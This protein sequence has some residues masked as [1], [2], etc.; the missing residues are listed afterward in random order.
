LNSNDA[1]L[2]QT[3]RHYLLGELTPEDSS[4]VEERLLIDDDF[5]HELLAG[6]DDLIDDYLSSELSAEGKRLF[7]N[8]FMTTPERREKLRFARGLKKYV[9][10]VG[11]VAAQTAV[12]GVTSAA[13]SKAAKPP[14]DK[15]GWSWFLPRQNPALSYSLAAASFL[16]V[17]VGAV[18]II[19][20]VALKP[21]TE[22]RVL[23]VELASGLT[24]SDEQIKTFSV[25]N[26]DTVELDLRIDQSDDYQLYRGVLQTIDGAE[27][28]RDDVPRTNS[29]GGAVVAL[30]IPARLLGPGSY[31]VKLSGLNKQGQYEDLGRYSFRVTSR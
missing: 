21:Q 23:A 9:S 7:D 6:E 1:N 5:Y 13:P 29:S 19:R 28:L 30:R 26:A 18:A 25:S 4:Q 14:P 22:G 27:K 3:V 20:T 17:V 2:Q 12:A 15:R 24:R 16:I 10:Q 8:H 31:Y 11:A